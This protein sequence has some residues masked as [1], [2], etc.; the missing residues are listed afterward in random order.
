M[1]TKGE[2]VTMLAK[3]CI[4]KP[5]TQAERAA[6]MTGMQVNRPSPHLNYSPA[7]TRAR[8]AIVASA[9]GRVR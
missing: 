2:R 1:A 4:A 8:S 5:R 3:Q 7:A 6:A 9:F